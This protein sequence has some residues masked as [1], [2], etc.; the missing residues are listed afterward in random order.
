M[1]TP[2]DRKR[3]RRSYYL[4]KK[5]VR[6][7]ATDEGRSRET[8]RRAISNTAP[9]SYQLKAARPAPLFQPFQSRVEELLAQ[10]ESLP[11][12][13][14]YTAR[15]I[16]EV[17]QSEGYQGCESRIRQ[18][19]AEWKRLHRA[20]EV[21][22]PLEF[23]PSQDAQCDWGEAT[24]IIA[25]VKQT[26]QVFVMRL[27]YSRCTFVM[28]FPSQ[29]QESFFYGLASFPSPKTVLNCCFSCVLISTNGCR[30]S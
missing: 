17:I 12:K 25:G 15:R 29:K 6:Q 20:P 3:I 2:D 18:Y 26:V 5:S 4:D 8:I 24:A 28:A 7:I 19:V 9:K 27:C 10:N 21:F 16:F 23:D 22:L 13:Q 11:R 30:S 14:Q 1:L